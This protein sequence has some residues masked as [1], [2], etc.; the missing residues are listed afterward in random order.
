MRSFA[1]AEAVRVQPVT[2]ADP[3][4]LMMDV[5]CRPAAAFTTSRRILEG[6]PPDPAL[7]GPGTSL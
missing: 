4:A 2:G 7:P 1:N 6:K 5:L 3:G